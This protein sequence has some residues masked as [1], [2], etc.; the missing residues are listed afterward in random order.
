M[1]LGRFTATAYR[2]KIDWVGT[3]TFWVAAYDVAGNVGAAA[4]MP[5]A[6]VAPAI[7]A[8]LS[9]EV[10]DNNV[11][12][13][14]AAPVAVAGNLP[15]VTYELRRGPTSST[16]DTAT[17]IGTKAGLFT[18]VFETV[19]GSYSYWVAAVDSKGNV[20]TA[21]SVAVAV[22]QPPD[23]V[24]KQTYA[25][26]F[27]GADTTFSNGLKDGERVLLLVN[28]AETFAQHFTNNSWTTPQQQVDA[29]HQIYLQPGLT[30]AYY[31]EI[32][33][34][35]SVL[36]ANKVTVAATTSLITGAATAD[37]T[38][39]T[40]ADKSTWTTPSAV[41]SLYATNFRYVKVRVTATASGGN[42]LLELSSLTVRLDS[43]L[44]TIT[45]T[46]ACL[47]ADS[48]GTIVYLTDDKTS[49]GVKSF[50]DVDAIQIT[51][52]GTTPLIPVYDFTDSPDP[53]SFKV[54]LFTTAGARSDGTVS[55]T[56]RGF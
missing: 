2:Q 1:S 14:W 11:L 41:T 3:R 51:P 7:L 39:S 17:S 48:G 33:D 38:I 4:S 26:T 22:N 47:A 12:L 49:G 45:G 43:K 19:A 25:S 10:I 28:I 50:I 13:S 6:I 44:K 18:S 16:W 37:I 36:A 35:G 20:G 5:V 29:G 30:S 54:L 15:I 55:Y 21:R 27:S 24:L 56:V 31:E 42:D 32:F 53:L 34:Y 52:T 46:K 8:S 23:Y 40:S 9:A